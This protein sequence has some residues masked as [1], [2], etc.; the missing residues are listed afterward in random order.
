MM[1][2]MLT[3]LKESTTL[4]LI[5]V[6]LITFHAFIWFGKI[7]GGMAEYGIAI[8]GILAIWRNRENKQNVDST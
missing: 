8:T 5:I 2:E 6:I 1:D 4:K 3:K 7:T